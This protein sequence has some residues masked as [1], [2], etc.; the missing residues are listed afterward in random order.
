MPPHDSR[1]SSEDDD[2]DDLRT[3]PA[4]TAEDERRDI[5]SLTLADLVKL[6]ADLAGLTS[7]LESLQPPSGGGGN[8]VGNTADANV[9]NI[10]PSL[11]ITN[12][13]AELHRLPKTDTEE[14]YQAAE[15][16]PHQVDHKRKMIFLG[17]NNNDVRATAA[18]IAEY[19]KARVEVFGIK[20]YLPMTLG[21]A[22]G[23]EKMNLAS[24]CVWQLLPY[25][26]TSGRPVLFFCPGRRNFAEYSAMQEMVRLLH[27]HV[28][29][30]GIRRV[31]WPSTIL[32]SVLFG[33]PFWYFS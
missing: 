32:P 18:H 9:A 25:P 1:P 12:L 7:L 26:D 10:N 13:E 31:P 3:V 33:A 11:I 2:D 5:E 21:G 14:Y 20:A 17:A 23:E 19:W 8:A 22:M 6:Q 30:A 29:V 16:C 28:I 4:F 24:R 27:I 15:K